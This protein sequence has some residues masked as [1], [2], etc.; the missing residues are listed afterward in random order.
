[1]DYASLQHGEGGGIRKEDSLPDFH[2]RNPVTQLEWFT[3]KTKLTSR[4]KFDLGV[5]NSVG[6]HRVKIGSHIDLYLDRNLDM[7]MVPLSPLLESLADVSLRLSIDTDILGHNRSFDIDGVIKAMLKTDVIYWNG[8][9]FWGHILK[10]MNALSSNRKPPTGV[11]VVNGTGRVNAGSYTVIVMKTS[12]MITRDNTEYLL[13]D[14]DWIR[15]TSDVFTQRFLFLTGANAGSIINST[16]YP[17]IEM[18]QTV[19]EWGDCVLRDT[20]NNGFKVIKTYE[21]LVIGVIQ[22]RGKGDIIEPDRFL[23]NTL[24]DLF[25]DSI[26]LHKRAKEIVSILMSV[27]NIHHLTQLYGMHRIWGHPLVEP[28]KGMQRVINIG[29]K[30]IIKDSSLASDAGRMFKLIFCREYKAKNGHYPPVLSGPELIITELSEGDHRATSKNGHPLSDWDRVKFKQLFQLPETFNLSMIVADKSIS[31]TRSELRTLIRTKRT[32]MS[33]DKRRGV[34]R[35]LEDTTLNPREFLN[36]VN[37]GLFPDDHKVIGLTPKERE[38]NPTPRMFA[39]MSHLLRVY[40]VLTEQLIS[41]HVLKYFPQITMTDTLLDLTKK[42]YSTVKHQ[43]IQNRQRGKDNLWASRVICMSLDFEKWNGHMRKEMT[44]GVFTALGDLFGLTEIYNVTYDI[45]KECYYYL[46]DGSYVPSCTTDNIGLS[47]NE[48]QS[49]INHQGGMEGLRQK[50][51]TLFTVCALEV[52]LSRHDCSYKIMGMGDNQVLQITLYTNKVSEGGLPSEEGLSE[53]RKNMALI[54]SELVETFTD[55]GLPLKPL[56]TWMS[57]DLYVYGK[58]PVWRGVP[59]PMD[60]KKIMRMFPFS[61]ADVMTLE[62]ALSTISGNALSST[63]ATACIW[64]PYVM[65]VM[66]HSMCI[67]DFLEYHPLL[68][69]GLSNS[70]DGDNSWI[71]RTSEGETYNFELTKQKGLTTRHLNI[72]MQIV[73]RVLTGYNGINVLEMMMRGFPDNLSR[74]VSYLSAVKASCK[75]PGWL[76]ELLD[77]WMCP[78]YMP[79]INYYNLVTDVTAVNL[80]SPRSTSSGIKQVVTKYLSSGKDIKNEEFKNLMQTKQKKHEEFMAELICSG[81]EL[82]IK[83]IHDLVDATIYGYV[84]SILSKVVKTNTIQRLAMQHSEEDTFKTIYRDEKTYYKFFKWRSCSRGEAPSSLCPTDICREMRLKGWQKELRGITIPHPF[85]FMKEA[86]CD[87]RMGCD[88]KDGY[89][90]IHLPDGQLPDDMWMNSIGANPPYLGSMTKEKVVVGAGGKVYSGEPLIK[91]PLNLMRSINWFVPEDSVTA[92]MIKILVSSVSDIDPEPYVGQSEGVAGA[93]LHRYKDSSTSHGALTSSSYL[94]ST[95]YHISS[96]HFHR[97]CRGSENTDLHFQAL[98]CFLVEMTNLEIIRCLQTNALIP[99]LKHYRQ[100]CERCIKPVKEDFVDLSNDRILTAIPSRKSNIYLYVNADKIRILEDRSP[101]SKIS[102]KDISADT[103]FTMSS[104]R[105]RLWLQDIIADKIINSIIG[106]GEVDKTMD[107]GTLTNPSFERTM[108]T[109]LDPKYILDSVMGGLSICAEWR[110]LEST[111][112]HKM[113]TPGELARNMITI[114]LAADT[115]GLMGL[116]MFYCWEESSRSLLLTYPEMIP[117]NTNPM[118]FESCCSAL[119]TS[120]VS[121][122]LKRRWSTAT[123]FYGLADDEKSSLFVVKKMLYQKYGVESKCIACK[124]LISKLQKQDIQRLRFLIC[125][126]GHSTFGA[127]VDIPWASSYVTIERLRKDCDSYN[128]TGQNNIRVNPVYQRC[129]PIEIVELLRDSDIIARGEQDD[130][131]SRDYLT[132]FPVKHHEFNLYHLYTLDTLPTKTK[133]K[134]MSLIGPL[135]KNIVGKNIFL[136]GDGLGST[137]ALLSNMGAQHVITSTLLDPGRAIPQTYVHNVT[138]NVITTCNSRSVDSSTMIN[139]VNDIIDDRW[140]DSWRDP[141]VDCDVCISDIEIFK[142]EDNDSRRKMLISILSLRSWKMCVIK[143][144]IYNASDMSNSI[145]IVSSSLPRRWMLMTTPLRSASYSECWWVIH[146]S[147]QVNHKLTLGVDPSKLNRH[148]NKF[149]ELMTTNP[150]VE[151]IS[152]SVRNYLLSFMDSNDAIK[153]VSY[154]RA[155]M[156]IPSLGLVYPDKGSF[157]RVY[158]YL[159][160]NKQPAYA[161]LRRSEN[162][163]KLY[164]KDYYKLRDILLSIALAMCSTDSIVIRE[165]SQSDKWFLE[166][167]EKEVGHWD[168]VLMKSAQSEGLIAKIEDYIPVLRVMMEREG[169]VFSKLGDTVRFTWLPKSERDK[170]YV[171]FPISRTASLKSR[172]LVHDKRSRM[173]V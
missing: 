136:L 21:A 72:L 92:E 135:R 161:R 56:E 100:K 1:M 172:V 61:N 171:R 45:F 99:R 70:V 50:G 13:Y 77:N 47:I 80:L 167:E 20:G 173:H 67:H 147:K 102:P 84:D 55:A 6:K 81:H 10:I 126:S 133:S 120:L 109:K 160:K 117:P 39:L 146:D 152:D 87:H 30:N 108:Y 113:C 116:G 75:T 82:H 60:L 25:D 97:Y 151:D 37:E 4:N 40:V 166:W 140:S 68:G 93:E 137:S 35:W 12:V 98:Y 89:M 122:S 134:Y 110:W 28:L 51:W 145:K 62:N 14:G 138:P 8:M 159:K 63:Q 114:I 15:L 94:L 26:E 58:I 78:I 131:I 65:C 149:L 168:C 2:M 11:V 73:P 43:S 153:M 53:M 52:V 127:L 121:L 163:L 16:Q 18:I 27:T 54:F 24:Q 34:K 106:M 42:M 31:P 143:D 157:T 118:T 74:D 83:L 66:M 123:R 90:S 17:T 46:A 139:K 132:P 141:T 170:D 105:K 29:R 95:R 64:T 119:K 59:L 19:M 150:E 3:D 69:E 76:R 44:S 32:V 79:Q 142:R 7:T 128:P 156:T 125:R 165:M 129:C 85:S 103:Y 154:L 124:R 9:R 107:T 86:E 48:P 162:R 22:M 71:L 41:D 5:V 33:P 88:C 23:K 36:S 115:A 96:D 111:G 91:R 57:E 49:F 101:L 144:Y 155:W 112:H 148:W 169:L 164:D 158:Y 130:F 38:L 104:Y